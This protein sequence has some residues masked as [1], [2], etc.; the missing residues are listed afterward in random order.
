MQKNNERHVMG[1]LGVNARA[2]QAV[3]LAF[4]IH[5]CTAAA[6]AAAAARPAG[7]P[8]V[9]AATESAPGTCAM[10]GELPPLVVVPGF[11]GTLLQRCD[12]GGC[13]PLFLAPLTDSGWRAVYAALCEYGAS[14]RAATGAAA[15]EYPVA[16]CA[17]SPMSHVG[18]CLPLPGAGALQ[19]LLGVLTGSFGYVDGVSLHA[20]GYDWRLDP[21]EVS[22]SAWGPA[23]ARAVER[24][25][26]ASVIVA[27]GYGCI[28]VAHYLA[29]MPSDWKRAHI[30][31]LW[32]L[33]A[34]L[35]GAA[36]ARNATVAGT[37]ILTV[38]NAHTIWRA[39]SNLH[40][41]RLDFRMME[42]ELGL[43]KTRRVALP[44]T[45]GPWDVSAAPPATP[46]KD[47]IALALSLPSVRAM[48]P[49]AD[50]AAPAP[51]VPVSCI[52]AGADLVIEE[53]SARACGAWGRTQNDSV[54]VEVVQGAGH[55][56]VRA[57]VEKFLQL[58]ER[59]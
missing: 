27:H 34:P 21:A 54:N 11:Q 25:A 52:V 45:A 31:H 6:G 4:A 26:R 56:H 41:S 5:A 51:H 29:R 39:T 13:L 55:F 57:L 58:L 15:L 20:A 2:A 16:T 28:V 23:F 7:I 22:A 9:R 49:R 12:R 40:P 18:H 17:P 3:A 44:P 42:F 8:A 35:F 50:L 33:A 37:G 19:E 38:G 36:S 53:H 32:C 24:N 14:V 1:R 43:R 10:R 47:R 48:L 46:A 59:A 30:A